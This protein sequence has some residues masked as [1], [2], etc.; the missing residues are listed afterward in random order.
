MKKFED[1]PYIKNAVSFI[2]AG[3]VLIAVY[4]LILNFQLVADQIDKLL[5]ILT[6]FI[7]GLFIAFLL[8]PMVYWFEH[9]ALVVFKWKTKTKHVISVVLTLVVTLEILVLFFSFIIPQL[10]ASISSI[11]EHLPQYIETFKLFGIPFIETYI[12]NVTWLT[13]ILSSTESLLNS[14]LT[15]LQDY[16]PTIL[17]YSMQFSRTVLNIFLAMTLAVYLLLDEIAFV[18]QFKRF[19]YALLGQHIGDEVVNV[20]T[21]LTSMVRKFILGKALNSFIMG[22]LCYVAMLLLNLE[23]PVFMSALFGVTNM[24]PFFGPFIGGAIGAILLFLENP[25]H[26]LWF[27]LLVIALQ[28]LEGSVLSP[29]LIGDS[30][31]LPGLWVMF[32]ILFGGGYFGIVG[33][34]LGVPFFAVIYLLMKRFVDRRLESDQIKVNE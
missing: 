20:S 9:R 11:S 1:F 29:W 17:S 28:N 4:F 2:I 7:Y 27:I 5:S 32:A 34:F 25:M 30:M 6:P 16:L 10:V 26:A 8:S 24:I 18:R 15:L 22:I 13:D 21:L 12:P 31:G 33:M 23:Y 14:V 19:S 3:I